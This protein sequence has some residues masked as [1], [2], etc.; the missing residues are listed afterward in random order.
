MKKNITI[1]ALVLIIFVLIFFKRSSPFTPSPVTLYE[2]CNYGGASASVNIGDYASMDKI[3]FKN[4]SLSSL[5]IP[6]GMKVVLYEDNYFKGESVT[7]FKDVSCLNSIQMKGFK[8]WN[9]K[10]SSLKVSVA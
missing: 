4:D 8:N 9:D 5:K 2:N 10:T 6:A 1:A 3:K 7:L